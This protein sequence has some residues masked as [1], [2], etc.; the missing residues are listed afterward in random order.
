MP[1]E[2]KPRYPIVGGELEIGYDALAADAAR[3]AC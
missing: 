2:L 3:A 1:Y